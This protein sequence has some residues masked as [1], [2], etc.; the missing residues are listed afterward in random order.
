[1]KRVYAISL[2]LSLCAAIAQASPAMNVTITKTGTY[3]PTGITGGLSVDVYNINLSV[4]EGEKIGGVDLT[5]G[6]LAY[7]WFGVGPD[8]S[9]PFQIE[10]QTGSGKTLAHNM[11]PTPEACVAYLY[12]GTGGYDNQ[13]AMDTHFM[14]EGL[15]GWLPAI[16]SPT[17]TNDRTLG[18]YTDDPASKYGLGDLY[19]AAPCPTGDE[20]SSLDI[21]QVAVL[22]GTTVYMRLQVSNADGMIG[23]SW[24]PN[25]IPEPAT[26]TLLGLGAIALLRR[27]SA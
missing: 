8:G 18:Q 6:T 26:M 22:E 20:Q 2:A 12:D 5:I 21:A 10:Y 15:A 7:E 23:W 3:T 17:E 19:I 11:T 13:I 27:R 14:V 4:T 16:S 24:L 25:L 9:D 1:M